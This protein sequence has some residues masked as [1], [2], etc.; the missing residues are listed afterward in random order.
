MAG[1]EFDY[2]I[3]GGGSAGCVLA[4]RLSEDTTHRVLILEAGK[5]DSHPLIHIPMGVA[6]I[7]NQDRFNWSYH[8]DP[9]PHMDNRKLFHPRGKVLGGSS[10]IN[11]MAYVRGN[12]GDYDR[13]A[14]CPISGRPRGSSTARTHTMV[15]KAPS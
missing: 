2:I 11:M 7:W 8:S 5:K 1:T 15:K 3:V 9:E 10:A 14:Y 12:R 13:W 6:K 4:N